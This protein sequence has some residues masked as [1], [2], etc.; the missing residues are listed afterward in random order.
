MKKI[1]AIIPL[2]LLLMSCGGGSQKE[3]AS[4]NNA[5]DESKIVNE[6]SSEIQEDA[7]EVMKTTEKS[8]NEV[9]SLLEN[10]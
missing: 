1:L 9:D 6:I 5:V 7:A 3:G 2:C 10:F 8:L 4:E